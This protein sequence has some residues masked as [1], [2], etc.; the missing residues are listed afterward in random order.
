VI[1]N[2]RILLG[3]SQQQFGDL[4]GVTYQQA[5]KYEKGLNRVAAGRLHDIALALQWTERNRIMS[6][7]FKVTTIV[8]TVQRPHCNTYVLD[9]DE[10]RDFLADVQLRTECLIGIEEVSGFPDLLRRLGDGVP[11]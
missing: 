3:L 9:Q 6:A 5:H 1:R 2:R 7:T 10:L 4:I 8:P 11:S